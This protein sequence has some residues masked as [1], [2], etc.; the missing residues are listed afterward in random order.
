[1]G[2]SGWGA[3]LFALVALAAGGSIAYAAGV[4]AA[5]SA[6]APAQADGSAPAAPEGWQ[7]VSFAKQPGVEPAAGFYDPTDKA[8]PEVLPPARDNLQVVTD[9]AYLVGADAA[10]AVTGSGSVAGTDVRFNAL[11]TEG[12]AGT[13]LSSRFLGLYRPGGWGAEAGDLYSEIW[14]F[15]EGLRWLGDVGSDGRSRPALAVYVPTAQSGNTRT[16]LA[17]DDQ[18]ALGRF[19]DVGGEAATDGS[20]L[21]RGDLRQAHYGL[22]VFDRQASGVGQATGASGFV[23]LP[24]KINLQGGY[25]RSGSGALGLATNDLAVRVPLG[26][27][28]GFEAE[29]SGAQTD[30]TRLRVN[31]VGFD[32]GAGSLFYRAS[33]QQQQ[34]ELQA[35]AGPPSPYGQR[36]ALATFSYIAGSRLRLELDGVDRLPDGGSAERWLQLAANLRLSTATFLTVVGTSSGSPFKDPLHL[37]LEQLLHHGFSV[38][39]EYGRI[40]S[41]QGLDGALVEPRRL[42]LAVRKVWNVATPPGGGVVEG[43][44]RDADGPVGPGVPVEL[45]RYRTATDD[46]GGYAF[47]NVP[48]G[49]YDLAVPQKGLPAADLE[50][51]GPQTLAVARRSRTAA[52]VSLVPL[53]TVA[54]RVLVEPAGG[55]PAPRLAGVVV[56]LDT[57]VTATAADGSFTFAN[58]KP[59]AHHLSV[60]ADYLPAGLTVTIPSQMDLGLPP[61]GRLDSVRFRLE[62]K[63]KPLVVKELPR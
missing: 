51:S 57:L 22:F 30:R 42:E 27:L 53:C 23:E 25:S 44:V 6:T 29:S 18:V 33:Y 20:W 17:G 47:H 19:G 31:L 37:R 45:G 3:P 63:I 34:G 8:L 39:A 16:V 5:D 13:L 10:T 52:D 38:R 2:A 50:A 28:G 35:L 46:G 11:G 60:L 4:A 14:G 7:A 41:F 15:A 24:L 1:M 21:A 43:H 61:G 40:P 59:G 48:A 26:G 36:L 62:R 55:G 12:P 58:V 54:G 56:Q 49:S 32:G 9:Q